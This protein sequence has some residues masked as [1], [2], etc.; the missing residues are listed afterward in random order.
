M[1]GDIDGEPVGAEETG[2]GSVRVGDG[3]Q[4]YAIGGEEGAEIVESLAGVADGGEDGELGV[5]EAFEI[6]FCGVDLP[7]AGSG[8]QEEAAIAAAD[9]ENSAW[10]AGMNG[11]GDNAKA[12]PGAPAGGAR[13]AVAV[14][15]FEIRRYRESD[16][17]MAARAS[18]DGEGVA[19]EG[20][21]RSGEADDSRGVADGAFGQEGFPGV[22]LGFDVWV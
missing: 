14:I 11:W 2:L 13:V 3:D 17:V 19:G 18:V 16:A 5:A 7:T 22:V 20:I 10:R 8:G 4:E 15:G 21:D 1:A 12:A 6:E 9:I